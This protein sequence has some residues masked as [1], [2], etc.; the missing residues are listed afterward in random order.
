MHLFDLLRCQ[1]ADPN[2]IQAER[3]HGLQVKSPMIDV[4]LLFSSLLSMAKMAS[5]EMVLGES[6]LYG[7]L[8][9]SCSLMG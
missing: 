3:S 2:P 5:T 4:F 9:H 1:G 7:S 8:V 6:V